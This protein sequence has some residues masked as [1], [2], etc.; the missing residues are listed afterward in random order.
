MISDVIQIATTLLLAGIAIWVAIYSADK[1][2]Q[3]AQKERDHAKQLAMEE[4]RQQNRPILIPTGDIS[5][6]DA[7]GMVS[8]NIKPAILLQNAGNGVALNIIAVFWGKGGRYTYWDNP[9]ILG[10]STERMIC[11]TDSSEGISL[12]NDTKI[13]GQWKL[14]S[15]TGN[16]NRHIAR[17]TITYRDIYG[18]RYISV[19]SYLLLLSGKH[20]WKR[21]SIKEIEYDL[22]DLDIKKTSNNRGMPED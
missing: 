11:V 22:E 14:W 17:L 6:H 9:P 1:A 4:R 7:Q 15:L 21:L 16:N 12:A 10:R 20:Q 3:L 13:D 18:K 19:F 5:E 2:K 8:G